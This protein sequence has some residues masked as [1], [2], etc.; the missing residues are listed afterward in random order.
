MRQEAGTPVSHYLGILMRRHKIIISCSLLA[1]LA[2]LTIYLKIPKLYQSSTL[3]IYQNRTI[4][5]PSRPSLDVQE[6]LQD[7]VNTVSQQ[8]TSRKSLEEIINQYD[9]YPDLRQKAPM[10]DV[11]AAMQ[12]KIVT[13]LQEGDVFR[14]SFTGPSPKQVMQVTNALAAR[15]IEEN[16][17]FRGDLASE[18]SVYVK[19]ELQMAKEALDKKEAVMR[20]Y[21]LTYYNEMPQQLQVNMTHLTSLQ[22]QYQN[23]QSSIQDLEKTRV[24]IQEQIALRREV[25]DQQ[26]ARLRAEAANQASQDQAAANTG[27][28]RDLSRLR[29]ELATLKARYTADHPEVKRQ[30]KLLQNML[31]QA[32]DGKKQEGRDNDPQ[33]DQLQ[34][35]LR[36]IQFS[37]ERL[38]NDRQ[39]ILAQTK[40]C[41][42][43]IEAAPIREAEW[44]ALTRD[45][46]QL[47][48]H[49]QGLVGQKLQAESTESLE[50][51]QQ[52]TQFKI[53]DP[54]HMPTKPFKPDFTKIL[55]MAMA[56]GMGCGLGLA[57]ALEALDTSF[58]NPADLEATLGLPVTCSIPV[59]LNQKEQRRKQIIAVCWAAVF[60]CTVVLLLGGVAYLWKTGA[61]II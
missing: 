48:A 31:E 43:W 1:I 27:S 41:K 37:I 9:L 12:K 56:G 17:R 28:M 58:K 52:G 14:V 4:S 59:L 24:M 57:F 36:D 46:E 33:I 38:K 35:Q 39:E 44:S 47:S 50:R 26:M 10:E 29:Q 30:E 15:F 42:Q 60:L 23:N 32:G 25:L 8:V 34:L 55:L 5:S 22:T 18:T 53:I 2:G 40:Q 49:Y 6:R 20:D 3:L 51:R 61:I 13:D 21:K 45:Y 54:A 16:L 7:M 19:D 11:V